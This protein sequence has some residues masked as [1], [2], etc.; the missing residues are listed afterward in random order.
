MFCACQ[1]AVLS[2]PIAQPV[3]VFISELPAYLADQNEVFAFAIPTNVSNV[4]CVCYL[5][6]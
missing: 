6:Y 4:R 3:R 2:L 1:H 5:S